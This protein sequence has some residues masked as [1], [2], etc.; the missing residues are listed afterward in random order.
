LSRYVCVGCEHCK[1]VSCVKIARHP[2]HTLTFWNKKLKGNVPTSLFGRLYQ[3]SFPLACAVV[4][5]HAYVNTHI[6]KTGCRSSTVVVVVCAIFVLFFSC[7]YFFFVAAAASFC[8]VFF[9]AQ[10]CLC[11]CCCCS[12]FCWHSRNFHLFFLFLLLNRLPHL[13]L[14]IPHPSSSSSDN[15]LCCCSLQCQCA[16]TSLSR[17]PV[18]LSLFLAKTPRTNTCSASSRFH[19]KSTTLSPIFYPFF[20]AVEKIPIFS[21]RIASHPFQFDCCSVLT[22][23]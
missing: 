16:V 1:P 23:L 5:V 9:C 19:F 12:S 21:E 14:L 6:H 18:T 22:P 11:C 3:N 17:G 15:C 8:S 10:I 13:L 4:W 20:K 7:H 2:T